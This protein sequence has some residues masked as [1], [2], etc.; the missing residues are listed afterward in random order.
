LWSE[1]GIIAPEQDFDAVILIV[2]DTL[3]C[4]APRI[5]SLLF[6]HQSQMPF[7]V[8]HSMDRTI[9]KNCVGLFHKKAR[10]GK[11][12]SGQLLHIEKRQMS[13][14][15]MRASLDILF[16]A[17]LLFEGNCPFL[18]GAAGKLSTLQSASPSTA[19]INALR[20]DGL[21]VGAVA[22]A[23]ALCSTADFS[24]W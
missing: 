20:R 24:L 5:N 14:A 4:S 9:R 17:A 22:I 15:E 3:H 10:N 11:R 21:F 19:P 18:N 13:S 8:G 2:T 1:I 16:R 23:P 12:N 7:S 6:S